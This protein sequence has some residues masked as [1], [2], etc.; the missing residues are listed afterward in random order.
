LGHKGSPTVILEAVASKDLRIWHAFFGMPGSH[1]DI[2]VLQQSP[3]FD[4][5]ANGTTPPVNF[6]VN[7]NSYNM[8]YYP[9]DKMYPDWSTL[10]KTRSQP[11]NAKNRVYAKAQESLRKDRERTFGILRARFQLA[12]NSGRLWSTTDMN[13]IVTTCVILHNMVVE[14][15]KH[16]HTDAW[17]FS[18]PN[19]PSIA[20]NNGVPEIAQLMAAYNK[21]K[22][23]STSIRL[24]HD[25]V[26][27]HWTRVGNDL[28]V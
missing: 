25:L 26:E 18:E 21:I 19:D 17:E 11:V 22:D 10:V 8:G 27:H 5:I 1:N 20:S 2:N 12:M 3:V 4:G 28:S 23:R 16:L 13:D 6:V 14:D 7:G 9:A 24:Q 15:E